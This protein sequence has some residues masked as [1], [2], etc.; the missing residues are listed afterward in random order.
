MADRKTFKRLI[1]K[2][3]TGREAGLLAFRDNW[4]VDHG[5]PDLLSKSDFEK[6]RASLKDNQDI[7]D[8]NRM[9]DAYRAVDYTLKM[10]KIA[11]LEIKELLSMLYHIGEDYFTH[12]TVKIARLSQPVVMTEKQYRE[13]MAAQ[14]ER[15]FK[16]LYSFYELLD[17]WS[18]DEVAS[19]DIQDKCPDDKNILEWLYEEHHDLYQ[20]A[21]QRLIRVI[22][23]DKLMPVIIQ[24]KDR[25]RLKALEQDREQARL[26][27]P[28]NK[29][30]REEL[31]DEAM[32][33]GILEKDPEAEK[34]WKAL[35]EQ[36]EKLRKQ[37]YKDGYVDQDKL[38][39]H[40]QSLLD[41]DEYKLGDELLIDYV[42]CS[43]Q[44][45]YQSGLPE[46][47]R[48]IDEYHPGYYT[49][50]YGKG[51]AILVDPSPSLLDENGYYSG[52]DGLRWLEE[53][54][55]RALIEDGR[56]VRILASTT[57]GNIKAFMAIRE[58]F[59]AV[60]D[61]LGFSLMED[62]EQYQEDIE[63]HVNQYN[64][65]VRPR[66]PLVYFPDEWKLSTISLAKLKPDKRETEH[67]RERMA[68]S[69]GDNWWKSG[70]IKDIREDI[71]L[72][73]RDMIKD[74][75]LLDEVIQEGEDGQEA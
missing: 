2:G 74:T 41:V 75:W 58:L 66:R 71:R 29:L 11:T 32:E 12:N 28:I 51:V 17:P 40:L 30:S 3:L 48:W 65:A 73:L 69:F 34:K 10:T 45:L 4:E 70:E 49:D 35:R 39:Q 43:G 16:E 46:W 7:S 57:R 53:S 54:T 25:D 59:Q 23:E 72:A 24:D 47:I 31:I 13:R 19:R 22:Q 64:G 50:D 5:R 27:L 26:E 60:S 9:V 67:L 63:G 56:K 52:E 37:F 44:D 18:V 61:A 68:V 21:I 62:I 20:E 42:F 33:G 1:A 8:Y 14:R 38:I 15:Q 36:E 55:S 6:M